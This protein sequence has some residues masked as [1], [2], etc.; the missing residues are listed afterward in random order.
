MI[1]LARNGAQFLR[2]SVSLTYKSGVSRGLK[3]EVD[4]YLR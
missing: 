4:D 3:N 2:K 1:S